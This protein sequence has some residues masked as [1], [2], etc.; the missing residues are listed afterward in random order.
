MTQRFAR[1]AHWMGNA[2]GAPWAFLAAAAFVVAWLLSGPIFHFSETWQLVINTGT[3]IIT[4]LMVFLLQNTQNRD[5]K[6]LHAKLDAL[7]RHSEAENALVRLEE[8][9]PD[10]AEAVRR[11][12]EASS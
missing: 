1:F 5:T 9:D 11:S 2:V 6:A 12:A 8:R 3:T 10:E 7:I 4:F